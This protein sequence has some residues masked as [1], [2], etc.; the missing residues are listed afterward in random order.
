[1]RIRHPLPTEWNKIQLLNDE[2]FADNITY[3]PDLKRDWAISEVGK[4]YFQ[5]LVTDDE[6][7]CFVAED[8]NM[9][10][11]YI[12][13]AP[14]E[15]SY[16][17]SKYLEIDNMGVNPEYRGKGVG[18]LLIEEV[19]KW[20][21]ENGYNKLF[22]NSYFKNTSAIAFYKKNGFEEIDVSLEMKI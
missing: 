18:T 6:Q 11:G 22:V 8:D 16:R 21:K 12:A 20:A 2:V 17:K 19:K 15:L 9:L 5:E 4:Q 10:V 7:V 3:D 1:M 13:A 14:K